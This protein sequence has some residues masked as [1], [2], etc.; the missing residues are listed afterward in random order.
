MAIKIGVSRVLYLEFLE[1][2]SSGSSVLPETV[3]V[4]FI[5]TLI[6][7]S[8]VDDDSLDQK[9][10]MEKSCEPLNQHLETRLLHPESVR[11]FQN[12]IKSFIQVSRVAQL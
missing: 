12:P 2:T 8:L 1:V 7:H 10:Q 5:V 3:P 9:A 4:F 11:K 6:P